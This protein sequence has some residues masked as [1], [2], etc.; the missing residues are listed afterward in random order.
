MSALF[1]PR[2]G[3]GH[4]T[5]DLGHLPGPKAPPVIG[6]SLSLVRGPAALLT[7]ARA[8]HGPVFR[9]HTL[10]R[11]RIYAM[12]PDA[13]EWVLMDREGMFSAQ[14]GWEVLH[15]LFSGGLM[16]RDGTDHRAHRRTMQ[17]AFRAEA[18]HGYLDTMRAE[19]PGQLAAWRTGRV[20]R[21]YPALKQLSFNVGNRVFMGL[22][23][24]PESAATNAAFQ[25]EVAATLG[26]IR[27]PLPLTKLRR[28]LAAR[29]RLRARFLGLIAQRRDGG[30]S[31]F[32][33]Q[34]VAA[35]A[36]EDGWRD[37]E[38]VDHFNF[39]MMAAHDT[40]ATTL[41]AM[42]WAL[43][44]YPDWQ[45]RVREELAA[46]PDGLQR[47]DQ[48]DALPV[49]LRV[50]DESLRLRPPVPLIPR[51]LM[52][53]AGFAGHRFPEG[54]SVIVCPGMV[55][56]DPE[57]WSDPD[58]FDPD[59]FSEA[60]AEHRS[61]R[62]AFAPF[63]GGAHKCIGMHFA[64]F[65]SVVVLHALLTRWRID[66]VGRGG[67]HWHQVPIPRPRDGLPIRLHAL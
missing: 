15:D 33:S 50:M 61:H 44:T 56:R 58:R 36:Q 43:A 26:I 2:G 49:T 17:A 40:T 63:G 65:Q 8:A 52:R 37:G 27:Q 14:G 25:T 55:H 29:A 59:R 39:L 34:M 28:G 48:I 23:P 57:I 62:F 12:G 32:F 24:G 9:L 54:A 66:P 22:A 1:V 35:G 53:D 51:R 64:R 11:W 41:T 21:A 46:L 7:G 45:D 16:L 47:A 19:I 42:I 10:G 20:F 30:G 13:L 18:M 6:H 31:D 60:Q 4:P 3:V 38:I 67:M 5:P